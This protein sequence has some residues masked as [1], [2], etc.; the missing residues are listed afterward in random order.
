M[1]DDEKNNPADLAGA[2]ALDALGAEERAAFEEYLVGSEQARIEVAELS[3]TAVALGLATAPV[4]P[5][6]ALKAGLMARLSGTAQLPPLSAT[7]NQPTDAAP[8]ASGSSPAAGFR[9]VPAPRPGAANPP[10]TAAERRAEMRWFRR[11]IGILVAVAAAIALFTGGILTGQSFNTN[12]FEQQQATAL[13]QINAAGDTQRASTV[14]ADG[15]QATLVWSGELGKSA[16]LVDDLPSLPG[17]KDYQLWYMNSAGAVSAGT[18]DSAGTGT[19]WRVL[20]GR[21]R[22]GDAVGLTVEPKG[23]SKQPTSD[24]LL[25]IQS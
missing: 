21:M 9:P 23:G 24:P 14:T 18:F 1:T 5:S 12:Q 10:H 16:L 6:A 13:A 3:D 11:P 8:A 2:Y 25:A 7:A 17:N 20:E 15:H 4:Q 22:A 19:A